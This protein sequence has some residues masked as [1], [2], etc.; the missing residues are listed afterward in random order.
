MKG[1]QIQSSVF[2]SPLN[3]EPHELLGNEKGAW[4]WIS[5]NTWVNLKL[6]YA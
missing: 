3:S 1:K 6:C 4:T 2:P 5:I